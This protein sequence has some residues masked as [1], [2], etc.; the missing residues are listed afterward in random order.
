MASGNIKGITIEI[1]GNVAPLNK[2]LASVNTESK[3]IQQELKA[4][5]TL[6][7]FDPSNTEALEKKQK[8]LQAALSASAMSSQG[9]TI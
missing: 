9:F 4:V 3:N 2:A 6:L 1:G 7:K 5:N 8:L